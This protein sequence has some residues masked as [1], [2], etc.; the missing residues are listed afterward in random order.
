MTDRAAVREAAMARRVA[1]ATER[2]EEAGGF[3]AVGAPRFGSFDSS[4]HPRNRGKFTHS[5][6]SDAKKLGA[7]KSGGSKKSEA[8]KK[9]PVGSTWRAKNGA[10]VKV[11]HH[12]EG[13]EVYVHSIPHPAQGAPITHS[14]MGEMTRTDTPDSPKPT[15]PRRRATGGG[16]NA[17]RGPGPSKAKKRMDALAKGKDQDQADSMKSP[18]GEFLKAHPKNEHVYENA[19]HAVQEEGGKA[20][21]YKKGRAPGDPS[22]KLGEV[23]KMEGSNLTREHKAGFYTAKMRDHL[24]A[25]QKASGERQDAARARREITKPRDQAFRERQQAAQQASKGLSQSHL[26]AMEHGSSIHMKTAKGDHIIL[27]RDAKEMAGHPRFKL[28]RKAPGMAGSAPLGSIPNSTHEFALHQLNDPSSPF[29]VHPD[30][31]HR[32]FGE[33]GAK[34]KGNNLGA[35]VTPQISPN[36]HPDTGMPLKSPSDTNLKVGDS[37]K[38]GDEI[39]QVTKVLPNGYDTKVTHRKGKR[40]QEAALSPMER[41]AARR[42]R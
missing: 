10:H 7:M 14:E 24:A 30:E 6:A 42:V 19:T 32:A 40:V 41:R 15:G 33:R 39:H 2:L 26:M 8:E 1:E 16:Q 23:P 27:T 17:S 13:G 3:H 12:T 25:E 36:H 31:Q 35:S 29:H 38:V 22:K 20:V 5:F 21:L 28:T 18:H 11:S 37:Y 34:P 9:W 4:L